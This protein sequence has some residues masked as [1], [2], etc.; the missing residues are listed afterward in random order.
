MPARFMGH[1]IHP[2]LVPLP[3][4]LWI[5]SLV[6]DLV[7][8][9]LSSDPIWDTMAT[10]TMAGGIVGALAAALPG[11]IDFLSISDPAPRR[12]ALIHMVLN[13]SL[14][15]LY[16]INLWLRTTTTG[17]DM[18][19][20]LSVVGVILLG[21]TGWLGG[22]LVFRHGVGVSNDRSRVGSGAGPTSGR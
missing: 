9:F 7:Y 10:Y 20:V 4:G 6:S 1:P 15:V 21:V 16:A 22:E 13:L 17:S 3:I 11:F 19:F 14:V 18:P 2:I 12:T 8:R 5:F